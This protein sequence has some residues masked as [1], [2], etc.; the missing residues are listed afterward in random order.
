VHIPPPDDEPAQSRGWVV[1]LLVVVGVLAVVLLF[2]QTRDLGPAFEWSVA[3]G[4]SGPVNLDSLVGL[5]DRVA[6]LSGV[7]RDGVSIWWT[8]DEGEWQTQILDGS[9]TQL[10]AG[11]DRLAAY[12]VR[13]GSVMVLE[14]DGWVVDSEIE[15]PA[16]TRSRQASG[17]PGIVL[18]PDGILELSLFGDVWWSSLDEDFTRVITNPSWGQGVEQPFQSAC[19]PPSRSSPDVPPLVIAGETLMALVSSNPAE[20]FGIWPACEPVVWTSDDGINWSM[21]R[22]SLTGEGNY[23]YDVAWKDDMLIAVGGRGIDE[24][25]AWGSSDGIEWTD[26]T[27]TTNRSIILYRVEASGAGW[28]ILGRDPLGSR[29]VGW[30]SRDGSCWEA[31]APDVGGTEAVVTDEE[32][33][34][35][36]RATFPEMWLGTATGFNGTC[37]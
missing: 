2:F 19:R 13:T 24:P 3:Q 16:E 10:A 4:P 22:T 15:L 26:I 5:D 32:I 11:S 9:P 14:D 33:L 20:P 27:P 37:R 31:L 21:E 8:D 17:R 25:V 6:V 7:T 35:V 18:T 34:I 36:D 28:V 12:R 30:T 29:T 1:P 23:V